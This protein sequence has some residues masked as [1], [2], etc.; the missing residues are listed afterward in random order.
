[1]VRNP[2]AL[3]IFQGS[4]TDYFRVLT[5]CFRSLFQL[6]DRK[7]SGLQFDSSLSPAQICGSSLEQQNTFNMEAIPLTCSKM[8]VNLVF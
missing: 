4:C 6:Q 7:P 8:G 3:L 1:M 2:A 5:N